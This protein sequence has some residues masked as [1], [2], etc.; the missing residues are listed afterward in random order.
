M[1]AF[2]VDVFA[3]FTPH[4]TLV[5][6]VLA[7]EGDGPT[8]GAPRHVGILLAGTDAVAVDAVACRLLGLPPERVPMIRIA[9]GRGLG[10]ADRRRITLTGTGTG[11]LSQMVLKP[12]LSRFIRFVPEPVFNLITRLVRL[13]PRVLPDLCVRCGICAKICPRQAISMEVRGNGYPAADQSRCIVC[14]CCVESC[15]KKAMAVRSF[16]VTLVAKLRDWRHRGKA[17]EP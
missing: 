10:V 6:A 5:D 7:M 12:S 2:L 1:S 14:F 16:A 13:R 4:L 17:S 11:L 3:T 15:P 8:N 9:A